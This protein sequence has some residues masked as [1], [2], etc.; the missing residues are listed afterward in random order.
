MLKD[1]MHP[2]S[3]IARLMASDHEHLEQ[4]F[5]G[6]LVGLRDGDSEAIRKRW[7]ELDLALERHLSLEEDLLLPGFERMFPVSA[8]CLRREHR[9][10]RAALVTLGVD[11]DLHELCPASAIRFITLLREHASYEDAVLYPWMQQNLTDPERHSLV[12]RL[13]HLRTE[14]SVHGH[15]QERHTS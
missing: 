4:L 6:T 5:H 3:T 12:A 14:L 11:L 2:V 7:L 10:I 1:L 9:A 15:E 8:A 13:R